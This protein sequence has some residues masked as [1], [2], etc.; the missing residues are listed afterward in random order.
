MDLKELRQKID[1][2]DDEIVRLF[3]QRMEVSGEIAR[4]KFAHDLP[5]HDPAREQQKIQELSIKVKKGNETYISALYSLLFEL[6][7]ANQKQ[8]INAEQPKNG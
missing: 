1:K 7:R 8:I 5:M 3:E 2:I 6:S 4:Y